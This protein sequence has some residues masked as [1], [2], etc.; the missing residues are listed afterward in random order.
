VLRIGLLP[1]VIAIMCLFCKIVAREI[2]ADIV[3]EDSHV[4]AF[5]D[6][7]PVAPTH[8]LVVPKTHVTSLAEPADAD[9]ESLG[10]VLI[11][12]RTVAQKLGLVADGYRVVLNSGRDAGQSVFHLHAHVLA[13][14]PMAWPPG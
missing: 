6:I 5:K 4:L 1:D 12:A 8:V 11:G 9:A 7:N 13:G 2:K 3:F 10:R 14:R